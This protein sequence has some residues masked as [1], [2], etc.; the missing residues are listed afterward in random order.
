MKPVAALVLSLLGL[1]LG[2]VLQGWLDQGLLLPTFLSGWLLL[3]ALG[4]GALGWLRSL[5]NVEALRKRLGRQQL[6]AALML[7]LFV[8]HGG[9]HVPRGW[10]E[11]AATLGFVM[12]LAVTLYGSCILLDPSST[13]HRLKRWLRL[14]VRLHSALFCLALF[15]GIF[16]HTHCV[17]AYF[18]FHSGS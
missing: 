11:G 1:L 5:S 12:L 18:L 6:L 15:H 3:L 2:L 8:V 17:L 16:T 9:L 13:N 7:S 4:L 14:Q 10:I